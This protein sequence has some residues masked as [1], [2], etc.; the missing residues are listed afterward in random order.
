MPKLPRVTAR[1]LV[2]ALL[3]EGFVRDRQ[4]GSHLV[5]R[6]PNGRRTIIPIHATELPAGTLRGI[7]HDIDMGPEEL[8]KLL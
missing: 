4:R 2:A 3:R 1:K 6:H 8:R 5:L 7:L